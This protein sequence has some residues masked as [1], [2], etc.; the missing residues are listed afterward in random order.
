[1]SARRLPLCASRTLLILV[2]ISGSALAQGRWSAWKH[3]MPIRLTH[4]GAD[5]SAMV[6]IDVTFS[7]FA[8]QCVDPA[9]EIRLILK[10]LSHA[11]AMSWSK[12]H[13]KY[14]NAIV[15]LAPPQLFHVW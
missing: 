11:R 5:T 4:R 2:V 9:K 6:P 12:P 1:M 13:P 15:R 8:D 7:L 10:G 3:R 14:D